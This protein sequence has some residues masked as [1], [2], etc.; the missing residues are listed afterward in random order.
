MFQGLI[1]CI[2]VKLGVRQDKKKKTWTHYF[3][4]VI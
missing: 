3:V 4:Y 2:Y 1:I